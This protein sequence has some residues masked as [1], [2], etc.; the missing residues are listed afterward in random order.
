MFSLG[1]WLG[2]EQVVSHYLSCPCIVEKNGGRAAPGVAPSS[3]GPLGVYEF[4][5]GIDE[6]FLGKAI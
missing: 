2:S 4:A 1:Y 3:E 5:R 6:E